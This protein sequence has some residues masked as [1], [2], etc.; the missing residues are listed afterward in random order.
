MNCLERREAEKRKLVKQLPGALK[1]GDWSTDC[2]DQSE[3]LRKRDRALLRSR[4][5]RNPSPRAKREAKKE[6][7][8]ALLLQVK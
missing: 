4:L 7:L 5:K 8:V 1:K 3:S 6:R 2:L